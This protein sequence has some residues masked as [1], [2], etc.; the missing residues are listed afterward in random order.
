MTRTELSMGQ[1]DQR[2][3]PG[4][5]GS[6]VPKVQYF[7]CGLNR[8]AVTYSCAS[9]CQLAGLFYVVMLVGLII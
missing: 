4:R 5:V 9:C 7:S 8:L 6:T 3:G 2:V 1:V